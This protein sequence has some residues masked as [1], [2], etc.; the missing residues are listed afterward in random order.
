MLF[1]D[2]HETKQILML[3]ML[4]ALIVFALVFVG[5]GYGIYNFALKK[6]DCKLS[7]WGECGPD[8][9]QRR[10]PIDGP[11]NGGKSCTKFPL[12]KPCDAPKPP[13]PHPAPSGCEYSKWGPWSECS[14]GE[15]SAGEA[16]GEFLPKR[17]RFR[18]PKNTSANGVACPWNEMFDE[19]P[20]PNLPKCEPKVNCNP[21]PDS[22]WSPWAG[23]SQGCSTDGSTGWQFRNRFPAATASGGGKDCEF[24]DLF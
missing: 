11:T 2:M 23:C 10:T 14:A 19:E 18:V 21:G 13:D 22:S 1:A 4:L 7:P 17:W 9:K 15:C 12:Q 24:R 8:G 16:C 5:S 6:V 3:G 20:C